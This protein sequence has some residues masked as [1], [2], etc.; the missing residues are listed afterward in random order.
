MDMQACTEA[1]R[2]KASDI[3]HALIRH[4]KA[5]TPGVVTLMS[6]EMQGG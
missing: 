5:G 6:G 4:V 2:A 1:L 3:A